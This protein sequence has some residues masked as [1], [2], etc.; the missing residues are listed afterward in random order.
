MALIY[1]FERFSLSDLRLFS[2][3][4]NSSHLEM[5]SRSDSFGLGLGTGISFTFAVATEIMF[6]I[7]EYVMF[8]KLVA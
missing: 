2:S 6:N 4:M 3:C 7:F 8:T 1:S 5:K